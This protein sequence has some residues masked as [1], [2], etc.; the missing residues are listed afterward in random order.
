MKVFKCVSLVFCSQHTYETIAPTFEVIKS[1]F[2]MFYNFTQYSGDLKS[3]LVY[4][5]N[6]PKQ[7]GLQMV[8]ISNGIW[9]PE[10][11]PFEIWTNGRHF[12][13]KP[14]EM[15]TETSGF[16]MVWFLNGWVLCILTSFQV[17]AAPETW[18]NYVENRWKKVVRPAFRCCKHLKTGWNTQQLE[19]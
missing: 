14:F 2:L 8:W 10:A 16:W 11:Q 4:I 1:P 19:L 3:N 9:N 17:L 18:S 6:G 15:R 5:S 13:K 12:V 7:V